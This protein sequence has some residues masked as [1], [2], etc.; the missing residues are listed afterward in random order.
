MSNSMMC[1]KCKEFFRLDTWNF[2]PCCG[3][4]EFT[5]DWDENKL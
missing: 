4:T 2:C 5:E 1:T 3:N